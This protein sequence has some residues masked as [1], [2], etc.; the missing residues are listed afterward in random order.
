MNIKTFIDRPITSI[1]MAVTLTII[2]IIGLIALPIEQYPDIAPPT[3]RVSAS[4]TG[5]SAET[6]MKSVVVPLESSINGVENMQYMTSTASN[7]GTCNITIYFKQGSDP[8]M[9]VVNVQNRVSLCP[10]LITSSSCN[11]WYNR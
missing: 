9:A 6:L 7:N 3:V 10:R 8:N 1:M 11:Q 5:A 4:Y 2:G